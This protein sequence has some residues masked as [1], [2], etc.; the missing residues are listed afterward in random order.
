MDR[1][2]PEPGLVAR[3]DG[4]T[5]LSKEDLRSRW[6]EAFKVP[7]PLRAS[8]EFLERSLAYRLQEEGL[9]GLSPGRRRQL[10]KLAGASENEVRRPAKAVP[11][12]KPGTRLSRACQGEVHEVEVSK[13]GFS[14]Q[15][16]SYSNL[17]RIARES[18]G[19]RWSG[20]LFFGL[21][22]RNHAPTHGPQ[23]EKA[24]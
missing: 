14:W 4:M 16:R 18:T 11:S 19:T 20:P 17:S 15:G 8:R 3:V 23:A 5:A 21:K 24:P 13:D 2:A 10:A 22:E 12:F 6:V 7:L 1:Q 9:G